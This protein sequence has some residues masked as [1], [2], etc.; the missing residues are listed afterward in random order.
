VLAHWNCDEI[1]LSVV[2]LYSLNLFCI[3]GF[4]EDKQPALS[5]P[6]DHFASY[7]FACS[8]HGY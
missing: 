2:Y 1:V 7:F 4:G 8:S 6:N 5:V 3:L